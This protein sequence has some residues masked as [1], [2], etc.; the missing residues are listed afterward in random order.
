MAGNFNDGTRTSAATSTIYNGF[1]LVAGSGTGITNVTG[2]FNDGSKVSAASGIDYSGYGTTSVSGTGTAVTGVAGSFNDGTQ[3]STLT[4]INYTGMALGTVAGSGG[5]VTNVAGNFDVD[6]KISAA[7]GVDYSAF[8]T[9]V[10]GTGATNTITGNGQTYAL[11]GAGAGNSNGVSWTSFENIVNTGTGIFNFTGGSLSRITT[12]AGGD[13]T[14]NSAAPVTVV[15]VIAG[16][17]DLTGT[18]STWVLSSPSS[19]SGSSSLVTGI[20]YNGAA[21]G[22]TTPPDIYF[23]GP[24]VSGPTGGTI[25]GVIG[26][27]GGA[28]AEVSARA[29]DEAFDT[30]SVA[31]QIKDGFA[32]DVGTTPPMDHRIDDTGISVP[33]CFNESREG[34]GTC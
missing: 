27:I 18:A 4:G 24:S 2:G 5:A 1:G 17:L 19:V 31:K 3:T 12:T 7:S 25:G 33:G 10:A 20:T 9:S 14:F 34:Q 29:L 23:N 21:I 26:S 13:A 15:A 8:V 6:T 30:D 22:G 11:T 28:I 32:G 16:A